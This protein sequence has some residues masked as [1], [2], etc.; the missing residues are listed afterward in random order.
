MRSE[1]IEAETQ[2]EA[3]EAAP[4]AAWF[5]SAEGGFIAFEEEEDIFIA[6]IDAA[7]LARAARREAAR[8]SAGV[9]E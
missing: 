2:E 5:E 7:G 1:F 3:E 9:D 6:A 8:S 4:W